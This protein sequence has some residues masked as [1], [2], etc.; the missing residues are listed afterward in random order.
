[1]LGLIVIAGPAAAGRA[2]GIVLFGFL[3][4]FGAGPPLFGWMVDSTGSYMG[5][6]WLA[7]GASTLGALVMLAW[8]PT[9]SADG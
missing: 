3:L 5:V 8:R 9:Q 2:S 4:G 7:M 1:M 6:W